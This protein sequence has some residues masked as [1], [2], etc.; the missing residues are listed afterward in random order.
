M[1]IV[2]MMVLNLVF[3]AAKVQ[4][5]SIN[6][7]TYTSSG[8]TINEEMPNK[9]DFNEKQPVI[10]RG[11]NEIVNIGLQDEEVAVL[12][13]DANEQLDITVLFD[14]P[15]KLELDQTNSIPCNLRFA[16]SNLGAPDIAT[17]R[18]QAIEV[19][20]GF[21]SITIPVH[22]RTLGAPGPPPTPEY[23][24]YVAPVGKVYIFIYGTLGPVGN[25]DVG[26]YE[27]LINLTVDYSTYD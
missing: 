22:R 17:A 20:Y 12:S 4:G 5:Q 16:Y 14:T 7:G 19:P 13:I 15:T 21:N 18:A 2:L 10:L 24:G 11:L 25:V 23:Q 6:F 8:I 27:G 26:V 3:L 9:L 1:K